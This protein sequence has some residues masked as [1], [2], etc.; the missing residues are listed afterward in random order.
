MAEPKFV[1]GVDLDGVVADF[2]AALR[3]IAAEWRGVRV[4]DLTTAV[5]YGLP[6]WGIGS[7]EEYLDLHRFAVTQRDIFRSVKPLPGAA[8]V[9]RRLDSRGDIRIRIITHRLFTKYT[10]QIAVQQTT[11]WLDNYGIP[12]WD[13][14][15]MKE[16][17]KVGA[18]VYI[19][20]SPD[21]IDALRR[22]DKKV[23]IFS[24]STNLH[25]AGPRATSWDNVEKLVVEE[26][27]AWK[28]RKNKASDL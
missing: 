16:K 9:L 24:N 8:P 6:E 19:E 2:Y 15:F 10:H 12:Y 3:P 23:I 5:T 18:S 14:C 27:Q 13:L 25:V 11:E 28:D 1:L 20:D 7:G 21:N 22:A 26:L 17:D 4:E